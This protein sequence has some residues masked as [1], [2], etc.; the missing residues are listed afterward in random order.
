[1]KRNLFSADTYTFGDFFVH[2]N[3]EESMRNAVI[4]RIMAHMPYMELFEEYSEKHEKWI[5]SNEAIEYK[6]FFASVLRRVPFATD[7]QSI[8]DLVAAASQMVHESWDEREALIAGIL[9][10]AK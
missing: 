10:K 9:V 1:M 3:P 2:G 6:K 8:H 7:F 4:L 5:P